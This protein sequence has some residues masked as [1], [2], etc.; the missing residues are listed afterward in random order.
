MAD[1]YH[2]EQHSKQHNNEKAFHPQTGSDCFDDCNHLYLRS[3]GDSDSGQPGTDQSYQPSDHD[4]YL[5]T[6]F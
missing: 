5:C 1:N 3:Y 4:Q 2:Y 6:W